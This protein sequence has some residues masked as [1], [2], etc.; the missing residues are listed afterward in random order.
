MRVPNAADS[1]S[2]NENIVGETDEL[3]IFPEG[4]VVPG[5]DNVITIL[6]VG[7]FCLPRTKH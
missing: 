6:Q 7:S 5:Q 4:S 1:S 3:Y 2:N